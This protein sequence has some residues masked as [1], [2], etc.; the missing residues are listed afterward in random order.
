MENKEL[1]QKLRDFLADKEG[2]DGNAAPALH[3]MRHALVALERPIVEVHQ[4][5][6]EDNHEAEQLRDKLADREGFIYGLLGELLLVPEVEGEPVDSLTDAI[7]EDYEILER[8]H[9]EITRLFASW[10]ESPDTARDRET[11]ITAVCNLLQ[12]NPGTPLQDVWAALEAK[13]VYLTSLERGI[14]NRDET[15]AAL[16]RGEPMTI[17]ATLGREYVHDASDEW[18]DDALDLAHAVAKDQSLGNRVM[19][20]AAQQLIADARGIPNG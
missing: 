15:I 20:K 9:G 6:L 14:A 10:N 4:E 8:L 12:L 1:V 19:A 3:L 16:E 17:P 13:A 2:V 18:R 11:F 5:V 7:A